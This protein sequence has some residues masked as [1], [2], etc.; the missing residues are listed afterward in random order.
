MLHPRLAI[1]GNPDSFY[2]RDLQRA[3]RELGLDYPVDV[4]SFSNLFVDSRASEHSLADYDAILVRS[5]PLGSLEQVIFRMNALHVMQR[6]GTQVLNQPRTLEIAIDKW[7]TLDFANQSGIS[8]PRTIACQT[9]EQ[10]MIAFESLG[11]DVVVKPIFGGEGRGLIRVNN[12]D[13]AHRVFSTLEQIQAIIYIQEFV[14]HYGH[15]IRVLFV[16]VEHFCIARHAPTNDWRTNISRGGHATLHSITDNQLQIA[17][18]ARDLISGDIIGVDILPAKDGRDLL[19][20]VNAVPGWQGVATTH[21]V[22][23]ARKVLQLA[24]DRAAASS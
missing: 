13:M 18:Q 22:D 1:L 20:E 8:V 12:I 11:G 21:D 2:T 23:I 10:S 4:V 6:R 7:L 24:V 5:M 3:S 19:L 15:D 14:P 16:G 17:R 9:R